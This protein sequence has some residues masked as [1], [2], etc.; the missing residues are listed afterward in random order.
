MISLW[1]RLLLPGKYERQHPSAG[2]RAWASRHVRHEQQLHVPLAL[3]ALGLRPGG[4][5]Q[6]RDAPPSRFQELGPLPPPIAVNCHRHAAGS[7]K[8]ETGS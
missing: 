7:S 4:G 1:G 6:R 5:Q 2:I 3:R 8:E